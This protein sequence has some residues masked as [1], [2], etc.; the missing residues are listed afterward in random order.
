MW[1]TVQHQVRRVKR[2]IT[3]GPAR[4]KPPGPRRGVVRRALS[5][6]EQAT[7]DAFHKIYYERWEGRQ[8]TLD[9]VWLGTKATKSPNDMWTYQEIL[10]ES[11]PELIFESGTRYGGTTLFLA[12]VLD[13]IGG[14]GRVLSLDIDPTMKRPKHPRIDYLIGSSIEADTIEKIHRAAAGRRTMV[15]LDSDHYEPHVSKEL[16]AYH[17]IVSPGCYLIVEDTNVNGRPVLPDFGAGPGEAVDKFI[18]SHPEFVVDRDR[19]RFLMTLNPGGYL[20]RLEK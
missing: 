3:S 11:Q 2:R 14:P 13:M 19:E 5:P 1:S 15:I 6:E 4:P 17:D 20:R 18:A 16:N 8:H 7:V 12:S 10:V 9:L